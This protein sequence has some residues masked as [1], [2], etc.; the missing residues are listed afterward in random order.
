MV[1]AGKRNI[2][3]GREYDKYFSLGTVQMGEIT[4]RASGSV[5]E[6]VQDMKQIATKYKGDM[7]RIAQVLKGN[8]T[9]DTA[10]NIWNFVYNHIQYKKDHP[11]REQIRTPL[12]TWKDRSLGVDC[13]CYS[14]FISSILQ[15]LNIAHSFRITAYGNDFQHVYIV[16]HDGNK[17]IIIDCVT[18]SFNYEV[19]Y[20]RK[21]DFKVMSGS[22]LNGLGECRTNQPSVVYLSEETLAKRGYIFTANVLNEL[23]IAFTETINDQGNVPQINATIKGN[24]IVLPTAITR[25]RAAQI[26][27]QYLSGEETKPGLSGIE[28]NTGTVLKTLGIGALLYYFF[29]GDNEAGIAG[30]A[31]KNKAKRVPVIQI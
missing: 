18:D 30:L 1:A 17:E 9:K 21:K 26:K 14:V 7:K 13:D 27:L 25:E 28:I 10:R 15:S 2:K 3:S 11:L 6:T 24:A 22:S 8:T 31:G 29:K 19:P 20:T 16:V 5:D 23:G 12:R 4:L